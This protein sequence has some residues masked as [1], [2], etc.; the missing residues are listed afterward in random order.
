MMQALALAAAF[1]AACAQQ[2]TKL[3]L[4][5]ANTIE[6]FGM[7]WYGSPVSALLDEPD[8]AGDPANG[9]GGV[10]KTSWES[11]W[12][13]TY[14]NGPQIG[15]FALINLNATVQLESIWLYRSWGKFPL[16]ISFGPGPFNSTGAWADQVGQPAGQ[17]WISLANCSQMGT[18][19]PV[20]QYITISVG[21]PSG[22]DLL[23][24][25]VYGTVVGPPAAPPT[26]GPG[27]QPANPPLRMLLGA[28]GFAN[29]G[30]DNLTAIGTLREYQNWEWTEHVQ[31]LNEFQ[32]TYD[33]GF[34]LDTWYAGL[35][36]MGVEAHVCIQQSPSYIHNS[37]DERAWKP[38]TDA[39][40]LQPGS[41]MIPASYV[42]A[43]DHFF[44]VA[45]RYGQTAVPA[46]Q[47]KLAPNQPVASGLGTLSWIELFNEPNGWWSGRQAFF[48]PYE[49]AAMLSAVYDG[50]GGT[51]GQGMGVKT[52]DPKMKLSAAGLATNTTDYIETMRLWFLANRADGKFAADAINFHHY[53]NDGHFKS[54][55]TV[56][57]SPEDDQF[58]STISGW[59]AYRDQWLPGVELWITEFGYDDTAPSDQRAPAIGP[60]SADVVQGQWLLRSV[61][62]IA[63]T[64][65]VQRAHMYMLADVS[66][67]SGGVYATSGLLTDPGYNAKPSWFYYS[68]FLSWLG[69]FTYSSATIIA[70]Q[71]SVAGACFTNAANGQKGLV[72]WSPTSNATVISSVSVT[73]GGSS[74]SCGLS[75]CSGGSGSVSYVVPTDGKTTGTVTQLSCSNGVVVVPQISETPIILM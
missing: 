12:D 60:N 36:S 31:D 24:I 59:C 40:L 13:G 72:F 19:A 41:A 25:V 63:S 55:A 64:Q 75:S 15:P 27:P 11:T 50:H 51:M 71:P 62:A 56:G 3:S 8:I 70:S 33:V 4:S 23:E 47:L 16:N 21:G 69:N 67:G 6:G 52:A 1:G 48:A 46:A 29:A 74:A 57:I 14:Y 66:T 49:Y 73:V 2:Q 20:G 37:S 17:G 34:E 43:S 44:Q 26:P 35:K 18:S 45:A 9:K 28:N 58:A 53:S 30:F 54:T 22:N 7:E 39:Q 5:A 61:L 65:C 68:T 42:R 10:P 38:L 32:P